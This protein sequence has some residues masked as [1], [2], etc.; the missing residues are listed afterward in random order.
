MASNFVY[1]AKII[2]GNTHGR[3]MKLP[4]LF[5]HSRREFLEFLAV[6]I[7]STMRTHFTSINVFSKIFVGNFHMSCHFAP[8]LRFSDCFD[9]LIYERLE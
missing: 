1:S 7:Y 4:F 2:V 5:E 6:Y 8:L 9:L 3:S